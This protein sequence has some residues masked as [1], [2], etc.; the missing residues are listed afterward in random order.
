MAKGKTISRWEIRIFGGLLVVV[1]LASL[2]S[3]TVDSIST[4]A[5]PALRLTGLIMMLAGMGMLGG[6]YYA[7]AITRKRTRERELKDLLALTP[8]QFEHAMAT[9]LHDLG[10][11]RIE[12]V[13][14]SNDLGADL[15]ALSPDGRHTVVQCKRLAPGSKVNSPDIQ[16]F[17]GMAKVHHRADHGIFVTTANFTAPAVDLA[18]IH[19]ITLW[20]GN[21]L[22]VTLATIHAK[23][24]RSAA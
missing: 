16:T 7:F 1:I 5:H 3:A 13:G 12:H 17:I 2:F 8:T 15:S 21:Y 24:Q 4:A 23:H 20:D 19:G 10:Y 14:R 6:L 9:L 18:R 11:R 22:A